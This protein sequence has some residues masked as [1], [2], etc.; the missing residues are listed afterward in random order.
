MLSVVRLWA[1][2]SLSS[3]TVLLAHNATSNINLCNTLRSS[4]ALNSHQITLTPCRARSQGSP[5]IYG[6]DSPWQFHFKGSDSAD[7]I[8]VRRLYMP[9]NE[10]LSL[11]LL[12][13]SRLK[14][15]RKQVAYNSE[16]SDEIVITTKVERKALYY[17]V[18]LIS[19]RC[20]DNDNMV[21]SLDG[22]ASMVL[23]NGPRTGHQPSRDELCSRLEGEM[24]NFLKT[25]DLLRSVP[26]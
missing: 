24:M 21:C 18:L 26:Y 23:I 11:R 6:F 13:T 16:A 10:L 5:V 25:W 9:I 4:H 15:A 14:A 8:G 12:I 2:V 7:L 1:S 19:S 20:H 17:E 22:S 3:F